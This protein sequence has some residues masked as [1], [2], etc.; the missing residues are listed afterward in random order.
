M[1]DLRSLGQLKTVEEKRKGLDYAKLAA[2]FGAVTGY[3]D[4]ITR[5]SIFDDKAMNYISAG[6]ALSSKD[7][8]EESECAL[9]LTGN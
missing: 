1:F 2:N 3:G 8:G 4:Y 9:G 5:L 7:D 6:T